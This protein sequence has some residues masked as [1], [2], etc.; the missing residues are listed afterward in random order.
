[1]EKGKKIGTI[2]I[3][4]KWIDLLPIFIENIQYDNNRE[5]AISELE[6]IC[7]ITDI[8]RQAQKTNDVTGLVKKIFGED[9]RITMVVD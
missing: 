4:P 6:K 9:C 2:D 1:M 3:E 7:K 8:V 5:Y